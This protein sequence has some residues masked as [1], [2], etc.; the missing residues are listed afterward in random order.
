[1]EP[2]C[3]CARA[4]HF[5][6]MV[7]SQSLVHRRSKRPTGFTHVHCPETAPRVCVCI[8]RMCC[9]C[10]RTASS[11]RGCSRRVCIDCVCVLCVCV[12]VCV[13]A[14]SSSRGLSRR[15]PRPACWTIPASI[16]WCWS[17]PRFW[18]AATCCCSPCPVHR[19]R[20]RPHRPDRPLTGDSATSRRSTGLPAART[21]LI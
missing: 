11:N 14:A 2:I 18:T 17:W 3:T 15:C 10:V 21:D 12:C 8:D 19:P 6:T 1:M 9:V 16:S 7:P 20:R 13:R 5:R 4:H